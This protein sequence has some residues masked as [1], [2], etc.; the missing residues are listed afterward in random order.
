M[1]SYLAVF[2]GGGLGSITRFGFSKIITGNFQTINP[3]S[4]LVSNVLASMVLGVAL[5][6][7]APRLNNTNSAYNI[8]LMA[9]ILTGFCGGFS[10]FSTFS[11][12]T[13]EL[14]K[15]GNYGWAIGNL[16][17]SIA[18]GILVFYIIARFIR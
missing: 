14:I 9:G 15:M 18:L 10:T 11:F 17:I 1:Y 7:L 16:L 8:P 2:I 3:V 6:L 13:Y 12:E 4:T 5:F